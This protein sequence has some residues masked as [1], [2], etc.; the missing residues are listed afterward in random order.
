LAESALTGKGTQLTER[1]SPIT[2][3]GAV[4][5]SFQGRLSSAKGTGWPTIDVVWIAVVRIVFER[6]AFARI[7]FARIA[8]VRVVF[9][10]CFVAG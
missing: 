7:A 9:M 2:V 10:A 3:I 4:R 5:R 8:F 1:K 6:S